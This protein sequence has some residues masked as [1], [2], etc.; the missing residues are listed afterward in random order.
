LQDGPAIY[1]VSSHGLSLY[2]KF[3][4]HQ[5]VQADDE[6]DDETGEGG[7]MEEY[8]EDQATAEVSGN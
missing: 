6:G 7:S 5:N 4:F 2:F 8:D 3:C 1:F